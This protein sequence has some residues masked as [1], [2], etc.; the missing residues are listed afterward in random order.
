[1]PNPRERVQLDDDPAKLPEL[2]YERERL[3]EELSRSRR[4]ADRHVDEHRAQKCRAG[5]LRIPYRPRQLQRASR[6]LDR[7]RVV[8]ASSANRTPEEMRAPGLIVTLAAEPRK[9]GVGALDDLVP[10]TTLIKAA[11]QRAALAPP[12]EAALPEVLRE[13]VPLEQVLVPLLQ[14]AEQKLHRRPV[15]VAAHHLDR[16]VQPRRKRDAL[17]EIIDTTGIA[18][19]NT[20]STD[21]VEHSRADIVAAGTSRVVGFYPTYFGFYPYAY[22]VQNYALAQ[23]QAGSYGSAGRNVLRGPN[24][25][26]YDVSLFRNFVFVEGTRLEFRA[27]A[28]NLTNSSFFA[29]PTVTNVNA[30]NFG[31][32]TTLAPGFGPRTL[33]FGFR[34]VY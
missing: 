27:E 25:T 28:Y 6:I 12:H 32:S 34:L 19:G 33:Q 30:G 26:S 11:E 17:V 10:L 22:D 3:L 31:Q 13:A 18:G 4:V 24:F 15:V 14:T 1:M 16:E 23:P 2:T 20:R 9:K 5:K 7:S 29:N 8:T 21:V